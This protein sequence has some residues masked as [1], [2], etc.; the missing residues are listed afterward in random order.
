MF[1]E[2][3]NV[4]EA[5]YRT[6]IAIKHNGRMTEITATFVLRGQD[7]KSAVYAAVCPRCSVGEIVVAVKLNPDGT[8]EEAPACPTLCIDCENYLDSMLEPGTAK[9][10]GETHDRATLNKCFKAMNMRAWD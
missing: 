7:D 2:K 6:A 4:P 5:S 3:M 8:F 10:I 9:G 1:Q